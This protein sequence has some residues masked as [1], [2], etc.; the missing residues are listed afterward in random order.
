MSRRWST[1]DGL[2]LVEGEPQSSCYG[3]QP[4][5]PLIDGAHVYTLVQPATGEVRQRWAGGEV[6]NPPFTDHEDITRFVVIGNQ[7]V[8][9]LFWYSE[10]S[11]YGFS[12]CVE[13]PRTVVLEGL[14]LSEG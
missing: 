3:S 13:G 1:P 4:V 8:M 9:V 6:F 7:L 5:Q 14:A 2:H 12:R 11:C 10:D